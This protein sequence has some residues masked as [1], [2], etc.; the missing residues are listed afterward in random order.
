MWTGNNIPE[1][2]TYHFVADDPVVTVAR[3]IEQTLTERLGLHE[4]VENGLLIGGRIVH[5][6]GVVHTSGLS[7]SRKSGFS[8]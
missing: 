6:E 7:Y 1:Q 8:F 2:F 4:H 3:V 5:N